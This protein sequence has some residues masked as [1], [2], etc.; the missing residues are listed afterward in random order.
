[1]LRGLPS[2]MDASSRQHLPPAV[3]S[4]A[5]QGVQMCALPPPATK[6]V[7]SISPALRFVHRS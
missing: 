5:V 4:S 7:V 2:T 1:M 6:D 3:S